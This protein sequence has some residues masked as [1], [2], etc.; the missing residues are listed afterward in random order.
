MLYNDLIRSSIYKYCA[1]IFV[2]E[3]AK[4]FEHYLIKL[5]QTIYREAFC[6]NIDYSEVLLKPLHY[7]MKFIS[8]C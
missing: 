1:K 7:I 5:D 4:L 8:L 6:Y 3:F 2:V